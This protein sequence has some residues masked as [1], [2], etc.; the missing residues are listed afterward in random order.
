MTVIGEWHPCPYLNSWAF[1]II[2]SMP[3][4]FRNGNEK[5]V[6]WNWAVGVTP[7]SCGPLCSQ[8]GHVTGESDSS[9]PAASKHLL[10]CSRAKIYGAGAAH[11]IN[12]ALRSLSYLFFSQVLCSSLNTAVCSVFYIS[13]PS[14]IFNYLHLD[15]DLK[16]LPGLWL[17]VT[18]ISPPQLLVSQS[19]LQHIGAHSEPLPVPNQ[20]LTSCWIW[21][22]TTGP[23][24]EPGRA[25]RPVCALVRCLWVAGPQQEMLCQADGA[26]CRV[27]DTM[28]SQRWLLQEEAS[29]CWSWRDSEDFTG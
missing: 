15:L 22:H 2:F 11:A 14:F 8:V 9:I 24:Q 18:P 19:I 28:W 6:W 5:A 4:L 27:Q 17:W 3:V 21:S 23:A 26:W 10:V 16:C 13:L 1:F 25:G 12:V 29:C 7:L 20:A